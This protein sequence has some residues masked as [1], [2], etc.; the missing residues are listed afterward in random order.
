[1]TSL[2]TFLT[3]RRGGLD[4]K[5]DP[6]GRLIEWKLDS[7]TIPEFN[8]RRVVFGRLV[9]F[10]F[11]HWHELSP[12]LIHV[13]DFDSLHVGLSL[14]TAFSTPLVLTV[15]R[16]PTEWWPRRYCEDEKDC[17]METARVHKFVD[18]IVV[19]SKASRDVLKAQGFRRV[20]VIPH[21]ISKHLLDFQDDPS[22]LDELHLPADAE[23]VFC[24]CR[25]DE[26]KDLPVFIRGASLLRGQLEKRV[27]F[28]VTSMPTESGTTEPPEI[29]ELRAIAHALGLVEGQDIFFTTPF[30]YGSPLATI[31]RRASVV[32][33]PSLHES[34]GQ[35]ILDAFMFGK[36]VVARARA[37]LKDIVQNGVNGLLFEK[38]SQMAWQ[39]RR[40]LMD[41]GL[42][43]RIVETA[44]RELAQQYSV[45]RM[46]KEYRQLY[47]GVILRKN[48]Q[49]K[50]PPQPCG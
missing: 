9:S 22:V 26:H 30:R 43:T 39:V 12:E 40:S 14:R 38:A 42:V 17:F 44:K 18:Q 23:V 37:A 47:D 35:T 16:A 7:R 21:G 49:E 32:V 24:P 19:P 28:L 41:E 20:Q 36:P 31:Y 1:M 27:V 15:H 3:L 48:R 8:G 5:K 13:H 25:A 2:L 4:Y 34:F 29:R 10:A 46:V 45:E 50:R 33:V 11:E 6:K